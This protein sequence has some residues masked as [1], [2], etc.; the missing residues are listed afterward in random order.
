MSALSIEVPFPVFQDRD[1][2]PLENGYV[3]LGVA[4]LNPQVN[5]V[6]AYFDKALTIPAAQPLR[7][8][9]GYIS[10]AGTPAQVYVDGANFSILVQDSKGSMV[11]NFPEGAGTSPNAVNVVYDPA[12]IG[13]VPTTVQTKLRESVSVKDFGAVGDGVTDDTAAV[14]AALNAA[15][16]TGGVTV[17]LVKG[18]RY[19]ID[20]A[21]LI[22]PVRCG[23]DGGI[24]LGGQVF[25]NP[26][27]AGDYSQLPTCLVIN[28]TYTIKIQDS[29]FL[30]GCNIARKGITNSSTSV[31]AGLDNVRAY[32]GTAITTDGN[33]STIEDLFIIGFNYAY[34]ADENQRLHVF[35]MQADCTNIFFFEAIHDV[36][37]VVNCH[38]W[39]FMTGNQPYGNPTQT[40]SSFAAAP[41][42]AIRVVTTAAHP[43]TTGDYVNLSTSLGTSANFTA[44]KRWLITV[45]NS[46]TFDLDDSVYA[47]A[48][49]SPG[50]TFVY[51][52]QLFSRQGYVATVTG[53]SQVN[54]EDCFQFGWRQGVVLADSADGNPAWCNFTAFG[55][56]NY[57][58]ARDPDTVAISLTGNAFSSS[59]VGS[60]VSSYGK[61]LFV[62]MTTNLNQIAGFFVGC[63]F[64]QP[65][66]ETTGRIVEIRSGK[67]LFSS[68]HFGDGVVY[69][70]ND[71]YAQFG[72]CN[73][74]LTASLGYEGATAQ[75][76][77]YVNGV[78]QDGSIVIGS[79]PET[80]TGTS[81]LYLNALGRNGTTWNVDTSGT[82]ATGYIS[83]NVATT[84]ATYFA[85]R[86]RQNG[87]EKGSISVDAS[88]TAYTTISDY[89][90]KQNPQPMTSALSKIDLLNP[91][92][93]TWKAN[94][95]LSEGFIAHELQD[96]I[97]SAVVGI[98]D[99]VDED[100]NPV[101]Q[102]IDTSFIVATLAA[103]LKEL[104][105]KVEALEA[106]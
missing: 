27:N 95:Q 101:Y 55:M 69:I 52:T 105:A 104:K 19:L 98:K 81:Q 87:I 53:A 2:Q 82:L 3:F 9:N 77:T 22:I 56:D 39:N 49:F 99:A 45:V 13:A 42:G 59:F 100:G 8:I 48:T 92:T 89:R 6:I 24:A 66:P 44:N 7:T 26:V 30:R 33:D 31:R 41:S 73:F 46:T 65:S 15:A 10:N 29:A 47:T 16:V 96:V 38:F 93:Y 58:L 76:R 37:R 23:I 62:N 17:R 74:D 32:A 94:G 61:N 63:H 75:Y 28:P 5:P 1:G 64:S 91:V 68:T 97:P 86:F 20:S 103:A 57:L 85:A 88:S 50:T 67:V 25:D 34:Y 18:E 40:V 21:D 11:Y 14:Q 71:G 84:G 70:Y 72:A 90:L 83:N 106:K 4:N 36:S 51:P 80:T 78:R 12:G 35:N 79:S 54:F 102:S 60:W 43:Y